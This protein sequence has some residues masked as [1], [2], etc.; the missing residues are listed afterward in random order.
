MAVNSN[1]SHENY[2]SF[3]SVKVLNTN[4]TGP[5]NSVITPSCQIEGYQIEISMIAGNGDNKSLEESPTHMHGNS[6][7]V[8]EF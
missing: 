8:F 1:N 5:N 7:Q 3:E 6:S 2:G 4:R